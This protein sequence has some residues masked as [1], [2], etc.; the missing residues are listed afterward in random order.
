MQLVTSMVRISPSACLTRNPNMAPRIP[1]VAPNAPAKA[2]CSGGTAKSSRAISVA[3]AAKTPPP[4][5]M[6][7]LVM[8]RTRKAW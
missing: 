4:V 3:M 2:Y 8:R 5:L 1:P 7:A 6:K